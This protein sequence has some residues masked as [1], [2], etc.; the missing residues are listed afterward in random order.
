MRSI[1]IRRRA[2]LAVALAGCLG[3]AV[4]TVATA[5]NPGDP[6]RAVVVTEDQAAAAVEHLMPGASGLTAGSLQDGE[7]HR[8]YTVSSTDVSAAVDANSG[9]VLSMTVISRIPTT[10]KVAI[11]AGEAAGAARAYAKANGIKVG[12]LK[13]AV[14]LIDH[15]DTKEY[16][17][18]WT[19]R[20]NGA[21]TPTVRQVSVNPANGEAYAFLNFD[22]PYL[23]PA[24]PK[25]SADQAAAAARTAIGHPDATVR[26]SDLV[27]IFDANG[28]QQLAFE[29][30]LVTADGFFAVVRVDAATGVATVFARG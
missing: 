2:A 23:A 18:T 21:R 8:F 14:E 4:L 3:V 12:D 27:I 17:V 6:R 30:N 15:G 11:T 7:A 28:V 25:L 19:E 20:A 10:A 13:E 16:A 22:R 1:R 24:Q 5:A 26:T 29:V 9:Q